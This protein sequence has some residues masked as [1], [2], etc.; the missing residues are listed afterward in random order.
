MLTT[1]ASIKLILTTTTIYW[2]TEQDIFT[3]S[4]IARDQELHFQD[5]WP[6][7]CR[8][9][10]RGWGWR[11]RGG[12]RRGRVSWWP[13]GWQEAAGGDQEAT[14]GFR[15]PG[16][17]RRLT[18]PCQDT[19]TS[20][21]THHTPLTERWLR[22][23][24]I[25]LHQTN[26]AS[27]TSRRYKFFLFIV[28]IIWHRFWRYIYLSDRVDRVWKHEPRCGPASACGGAATLSTGWLMAALKHLIPAPILPSYDTYLDCRGKNSRISYLLFIFRY[29]GHWHCG[30]FIRN[31]KF[32]NDAIPTI[33]HGS[34]LFFSPFTFLFIQSD[35]RFTSCCCWNFKYWS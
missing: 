31:A 4:R 21:V 13:G 28:C 5:N 33:L 24:L 22:L 16:G 26:Y 29:S 35:A 20:A 6:L 18:D 27:E 23:R 7:S 12:G 1:D 3:T 11:H 2:N 32:Q 14:G 10:W 30:M 25:L 17:C 9:R 34:I 19:Q 8:R 15:W